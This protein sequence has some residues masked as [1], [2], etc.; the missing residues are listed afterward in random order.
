ML[1]SLMLP[2]SPN[3]CHHCERSCSCFQRCMQCSR[4]PRLFLLK[5]VSRSYFVCLRPGSKVIF[6][7]QRHLLLFHKWNVSFIM[8]LIKSHNLFMGLVAH[9]TVYLGSHLAP[10]LACTSMSCWVYSLMQSINDLCQC[11]AFKED[12]PF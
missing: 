2:L 12:L 10:S 5:W 4:Q 6:T 1:F 7:V 9:I 8:C 11:L 3:H